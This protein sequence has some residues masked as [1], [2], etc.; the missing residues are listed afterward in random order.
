[1][2]ASS[3]QYEPFHVWAVCATPS[4][5]V[6]VIATLLGRL[7]SSSCVQD[8]IQSRQLRRCWKSG[9]CGWDWTQT[10]CKRAT[11][12]SQKVA[13]C[14]CA[15]LGLRTNSVLCSKR[16][17][18]GNRRQYLASDSVCC[19]R[20]VAAQSDHALGRQCSI[21]V[22]AYNDTTSVSSG[23]FKLSIRAV[24]VLRLHSISVCTRLHSVSVH[25]AHSS[26]QR[27]P[28]NL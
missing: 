26:Q 28:A 8:G 2:N 21:L 25:T 5:A 15:V 6:E 18:Q 19:N 1:M 27:Y 12:L 20:G 9:S 17:R 10:A 4:T 14:N 13:V 24:P 23:A 16:Q 22:C 7:K 3:K 11:Q